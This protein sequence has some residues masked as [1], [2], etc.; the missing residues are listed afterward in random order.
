MVFSTTLFIIV[1]VDFIRKLWAYPSNSP[2]YFQGGAGGGL[3]LVRAFFCLKMNI[4][5]SVGAAIPLC[6]SNLFIADF[7]RIEGDYVYTIKRISITAG[8]KNRV[9]FLDKKEAIMAFPSFPCMWKS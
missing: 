5:T 7:T 8:F 2:P 6:T 3:Q 4:H 9:Q 1:D